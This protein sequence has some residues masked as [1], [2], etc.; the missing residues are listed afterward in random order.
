MLKPAKK[1]STAHT[2]KRYGQSDNGGNYEPQDDEYYRGDRPSR[3]NAE[4]DSVDEN[5]QGYY[6]ESERQVIQQFL[7]PYREIEKG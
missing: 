1:G 7:S 3:R 2:E 5:Q 4:Y 6:Y